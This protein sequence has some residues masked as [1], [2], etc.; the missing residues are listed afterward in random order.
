MEKIMQ[1]LKSFIKP[2]FYGFMLFLFSNYFMSGMVLAQEKQSFATT[3]PFAA[4]LTKA[5]KLF[6][7]TRN[8]LFVL[9]IFAFLTYAWN[10][11]MSGSIKWEQIFYLI[12]G[13][14]ILGVAGYVVDYMAGDKIQIQSQAEEELGNVKW[15]D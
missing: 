2:V 6:F 7:Q 1:Q 8:A 4:F 13:L 3:G 5:A 14:T 11:I 9:A 10:A 15:S 12:V